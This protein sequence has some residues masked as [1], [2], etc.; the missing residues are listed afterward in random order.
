MS[1]ASEWANRAKESRNQLQARPALKLI[2]EP[3]HCVRYFSSG[4]EGEL[5]IDGMYFDKSN[6]RLLAKWLTETFDE[7]KP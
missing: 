6:A 3:N 1:K 5:Q 7:E 4:D 2:G